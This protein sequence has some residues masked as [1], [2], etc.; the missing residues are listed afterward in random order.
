[1]RSALSVV[2][3]IAAATLSVGTVPAHA[4][5]APHAVDL[6]LGPAVLQRG[7]TGAVDIGFTELGGRPGSVE[8]EVTVT[9]PTGTTIP[10]TGNDAV[11]QYRSPLREQWADPATTPEKFL[12]W[13]HRLP[14]DYRLRSGRTLWEG[15]VHH[16]TRGAAG[17]RSMVSRWESLRGEIDPERH[18]AVLAKLHRQAD[19][20]AAW[21][22]KCLKYFQQFS[23]QPLSID[24]AVG[25]LPN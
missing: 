19:D 7:E 5:P 25:R 8:G 9:V 6:D 15:L 3:I 20:A 11:G 4:D 17:A 2:A 21:R 13:F 16:Y 1:M 18:G 10:A 12:L 14:W 22:D 23:K 24:A